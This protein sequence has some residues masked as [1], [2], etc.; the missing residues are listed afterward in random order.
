MSFINICRDNTDPFYRYKM[1]PIQ[2]KTEGRGNGIKTAIV[3]LA[4]VARALGRPPA[5]VVKYFGSELGAQSNIDEANDRYL[6]N[7]VHDSNELQ[8][9]LDGFINKFVL[10]G[11]C[12]N[13]ETEIV[14]KGRDDVERDCKACGKIT[15]VD[16]KLKLYTYIVKNPPTGSKKGKKSA[17]ATANVVG[18]GKSIS[19]I[20][21]G[22]TKKE[23]DGEVAEDDADDDILAKKINAEAAQLQ[24]VEVNDE[25]WSVD[26]SQEAIAARARELEG[27][28]LSEA[29]SKFNE[30]GEWILAEA[31]DEDDKENLPSDVEIY[32]K[33][34]EMD[35]ADK[36]ETVQVLA[37]VLF[38]ENIVEQVEPHTGLLAKL[39]NGEEDFEIALLGGLER[40]IGV[41]KPELIS[42]VP[43]ILL[44]FYNQELLGEEVLISWGSKVS[45]K[46]VP[47]DVSKKVRKA[48]K[49]FV[50]WL[51]EAEEE[52]D[53]E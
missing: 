46:Y 6:V 13:P 45:K 17:T 10:C 1:P 14:I 43:A 39:V 50:K 31:G 28:T 11:S 29:V 52:S 47:K 25:D 32:K 40:F 21:S 33:I 35:I 41:Q 15:P 9:T 42:K 7:G 38:D 8:D 18:G 36:T 12:K 30:L 5:Y 24:T 20:A 27:L 22:Q 34:V 23:D 44:A 19:D 51:Q 37:Q 26:M 48:A 53:E 3:N 49:P 16:P 4:E 2:S